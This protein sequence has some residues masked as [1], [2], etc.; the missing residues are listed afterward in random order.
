M[1]GF[2]RKID[3]NYKVKTLSS[4]SLSWLRRRLDRGIFAVLGSISLIALGLI[5]FFIFREAIPLFYKVSVASFFGPTWLPTFDP[6]S[7]G[8][9]SMIAGSALVTV[10][11]LAVA[12]PVGLSAAAFI[13]EVAPG[14]MKDITKSIIEI[15]A[16]IPSVVYGFFGLALLAPFLQTT[17]S[18]STGRT[19]LT[20]AIILSIMALPTIASLAEDALTA[21]PSSYREASLA[22]GAT[23][24]ET[25]WRVTIPAAFSGL[26]GAVILGMGR[27]IGETMAVL[28]V[29][30]NSPQITTSLLKPVRTLTAGIALEM[31]ETPFGSTHYHALF[32]LGVLLLL[33]TLAMNWTAEWFRGRMRR[34]HHG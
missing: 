3:N 9:L 21:V 27:A 31:G 12:V 8:A 32:S 4:S 1:S 17:F 5:F 7:Y 20:A 18:L 6:P 15:L 34:R 25:M 26:L 30:G 10:A 33:I 24:W 29:A 22:M 11:A 14:I 23:R 19:A 13:A 2:T 28:M 16:G